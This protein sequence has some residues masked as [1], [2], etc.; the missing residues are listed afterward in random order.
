MAPG[1]VVP[2][3]SVEQTSLC[4][5]AVKHSP[6]RRVFSTSRWGPD[7]EEAGSLAT[8][9]STDAIRCPPL[10]CS[11]VTPAGLNLLRALVSARLPDVR[12]KRSVAR[13]S[14][15][16][17]PTQGSRRRSARSVQGAGSR[18]LS[19]RPDH[20]LLGPR[21]VGADPTEGRHAS[22]RAAVA[23]ALPACRPLVRRVTTGCVAA[24][25]SGC[26]AVAHA[27]STCSFI[28]A[29]TVAARPQPWVAPP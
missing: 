24:S 9:T 23:R 21:K 15:E 17:A 8:R 5:H 3:T 13:L 19:A 26:A 16:S 12:A 29:V 1:K 22:V 10:W 2:A 14:S 20:T 28:L 25:A 4:V 27:P 11:K 6:F 7:H 18:R